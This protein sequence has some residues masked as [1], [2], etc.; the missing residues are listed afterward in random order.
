[1]TITGK[2]TT[3]GAPYRSRRAAR[4]DEAAL[5]DQLDAKLGN[6]I[7]RPELPSGR[8]V[9]PVPAWARG[10][11]V[12]SQGFILRRQHSLVLTSTRGH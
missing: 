1:M 9:G 2:T 7:I 3:F 6:E 4:A 5:Q 12:E 10:V 11:R 8:D